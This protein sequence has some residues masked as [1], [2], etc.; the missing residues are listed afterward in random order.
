MSGPT[1][2][3]PLQGRVA[4]VTGASR[5]IGAA[6]AR[7]LA[8]EGA[9]LGLASRSG[10]DLGLEGAVALPCDVRDSGQVEALVA[11]TV[12]R[13]G[14]LDIV[15]CNAA[16]GAIGPFLELDPA[17][18]DEM[19]DVNVKGTI[20]TVRAALPHL[21]ASGEAD[22]VT[23]TSG[24]GR[25]ALPDRA[26][27]CA[28]KF[29]QAALTKA[30]DHELREKGVRCTVIAPGGTRTEFAFGRG[31]GPDMPE[32]QGMMAPEEVAD[33]VVYVLTRPRTL[34]INELAF[35]PVS[36]RSWG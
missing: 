31:R 22:L 28:T 30:L 12:E 4:L 21:L 20:H 25:W 11:A 29:A 33:A 17:H 19:V 16:V 5:G 36:E 13:F 18:V 6:T 2:A 1:Q 7:A 23:I 3:S 24:A 32:L 8:V 14:R 26:A 9:K 27:Y 34:R 10:A 35:Q 15:V